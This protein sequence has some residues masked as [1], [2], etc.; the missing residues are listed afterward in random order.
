MT[1]RVIHLMMKAEDEKKLRKRKLKKKK[2]T[3]KYRT[4]KTE[5]QTAVQDQPG[6][7]T[8]KRSITAPGEGTNTH[9]IDKSIIDASG[10]EIK[11]K[12][13]VTT[14]KI[15]VEGSEGPT[16]TTSSGGGT[17]LKFDTAETT[18]SRK[19]NKKKTSKA[20]SKAYA[21]LKGA[22]T[23]NPSGEVVRMAPAEKF[24]IAR[25]E[26]AKKTDPGTKYSVKRTSYADEGDTRS[27]L[28]EKTKYNPD[29]LVYTKYRKP[30]RR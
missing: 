6:Q 14:T 9:T 10:R 21:E 20:K 29:E 1:E 15:R 22:T 28:R 5:Y 19:Y 13:E 25:E 12:P 23:I 24:K 7:T 17:K 30:Q 2:D 18:V 8:T 4:V 16:T 26:A 11:L 27:D 3:N